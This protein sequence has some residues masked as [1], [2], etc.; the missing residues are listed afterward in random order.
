LSA[1]AIRQL[2]STIDNL[3]ALQDTRDLMAIFRN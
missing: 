3:E 2:V 1:R